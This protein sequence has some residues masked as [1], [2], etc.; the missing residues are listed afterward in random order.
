MLRVE[1]AKREIEDAKRQLELDVRSWRN[2]LQQFDR[3][4]EHEHL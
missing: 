3:D 1:H 4:L 2:R